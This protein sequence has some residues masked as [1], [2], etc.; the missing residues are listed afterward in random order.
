MKTR[1]S[2]Q[3][4]FKRNY[5]LQEFTRNDSIS[6]IARHLIQLAAFLAMPG[7]FIMTFAAVGNLI[8]S[9]FHG[10]FSVSENA[11]DLL[12]VSA[13]FCVTILCGRF[14][15][16][17]LCAFGSVQEFLYGIPRLFV[18]KRRQLMPEDVDEILKYLKYLVLIAIA[19]L[20]WVVGFTV[21]SSMSPWSVFGMFTSLKGWSSLSPWFTIG[22]FLL[23]AILAGSILIERFFCRYLCPLG[24]L[25]ALASHLRLFR[26]RKKDHECSSCGFC[27]RSCS[28]GIDL[29]F[30]DS[31]A[32]GE[33]I[34]CFKCLG[35]CPCHAL[36][37]D[38][39][40]AVS[41]ILAVAMILGIYGFGT[42]SI[43]TA[44]APA[45]TAEEPSAA[46]QIP[47]FND[48]STDDSDDESDNS[49]NDGAVVPG[50]DEGTEN[51]YN[52][53]TLMPDSESNSAG[54]AEEPADPGSESN[55][56]GTYQDGVF[57]G[58]G[59]GYRGT[60]D[61][62]VTVQDGRIAEIQL[63]ST[64]DD[65]QWFE[66][67]WQSI[68]DSILNRQQTNVDAV[69]G[70]TFSSNGIME[71]VSNTLGVEYENNNDSISHGHG[72]HPNI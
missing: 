33:C 22:G 38:A 71:A 31:V 6:Q 16:G 26:I 45:V 65:M 30:D 37:T 60:T 52:N 11:G 23:V 44:P 39:N 58:S 21:P 47:E 68:V 20:C 43:Q 70:A 63:L 10:G 69:S 41:G 67:A 4:P 49:Y 57:T 1:S 46:G 9:V 50:S 35:H 64:D 19:F 8:S 13:V 3:S 14:F 5:A 34:H 54:A 62:Q 32:S 40:P 48:G 27:N 72:Q 51:D 18:K 12:I 66:R 56:A 42:K 24:A 28:M 17:F 15:C 2:E 53:D 36:K 25:F 55:T 61:V 7:L 29:A 59:S